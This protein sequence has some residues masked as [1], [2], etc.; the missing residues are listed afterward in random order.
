MK[1]KKIK[2]YQLKKISLSPED[3]DLFYSPSAQS[4]DPDE[5]P[6]TP[7][8]T[9]AFTPV[10]ISEEFSDAGLCEEDDVGEEMDSKV[11]VDQEATSVLTAGETTAAVR[12][13][14]EEI[15]NDLLK[16]AAERHFE[17]IADKVMEEAAGEGEA[18]KENG[19]TP[20]EEVNTNDLQ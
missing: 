2:A 5:V 19:A 4:A 13:A 9:P 20:I 18:K 15:A 8:S 16:R 3:P 1:H 11:P 14:A 7:S 17:E 10:P 12:V 6:S